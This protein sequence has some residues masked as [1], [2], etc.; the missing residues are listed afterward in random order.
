MRRHDLW[1]E[2]DNSEDEA[3]TAAIRQFGNAKQVGRFVRQAWNRRTKKP[4]HMALAGAYGDCAAARDNNGKI[5]N[6]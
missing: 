3:V 2:G 4:L 1:I 5:A 6:S